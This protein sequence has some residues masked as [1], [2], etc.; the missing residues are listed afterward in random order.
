MRRLGRLPLYWQV[1]LINGAVFV[2]ATTVLAVSPATVSTRLLPS[3][4]VVLVVG[5]AA[6][7]L[8]NA[9][10]L[11][12][13][14]AP[15]DRVVREM[16]VVELHDGQRLTTP[17]SGHGARL[18]DSYNAMLDRLESERSAS[19]ARALAA[20]ESERQRIAQELHDQVG[21]DLTVVLLGLKRLAARVPADVVD[22]LELLRESARASL[23]DVRRV[24]RE[25]RPGVLDDLGLASALAALC[26]DFTAH[27]GIPVRRRLSP[28]L[29]DLGPERELVIYRVAQEA[30][31]NAARHAGATEV[32]LS[33]VRVAGTAV[34]E[35]SDDGRG[36]PGIV[37]GA[38]VTGMRERARLVG[39]SLDV[40]SAAGHGTTVRLSVPLPGQEERS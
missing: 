34:L 23:D 26:S 10:L 12:A 9:L 39:A 38:G 1:C 18:V 27:G 6:M 20:Q 19:S 16:E 40:E 14:L 5:L 4:A 31:T 7:L 22:E 32:G 29:P 24:A 2:L 21:Q 3:E 36:A 28:G 15:V 25:L 8:T 17:G 30:L 11:R 33:L 35:V 37:P 13:S